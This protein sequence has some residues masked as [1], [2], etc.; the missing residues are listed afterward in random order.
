M[1]K[2]G[3]KVRVT[4][5]VQG[6]ES[7]GDIT[8][9]SAMDNAVGKFFTIGGIDTIWNAITLKEFKEN[10]YLFPMECIKKVGNYDK[11]LE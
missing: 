2:V 5:I 1:F 10:Y 11:L 9:T 4:K 6:Y 3:D 8:W 7:K